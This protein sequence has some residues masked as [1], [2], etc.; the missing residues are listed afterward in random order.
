MIGKR[1]AKCQIQGVFIGIFLLGI[2][3]I[4]ILRISVILTGIFGCFDLLQI[5]GVRNDCHVDLHIVAVL[6]VALVIYI[7][8]LLDV[9]SFIGLL[10]RGCFDDHLLSEQYLNNALICVLPNGQRAVAL[11]RECADLVSTARNVGVV[12]LD[13]GKLLQSLDE[14]LAVSDGNGKVVS[15]VHDVTSCILPPL[16]LV[17]WA[18]VLL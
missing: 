7:G 10:R 13:A 16:R 1:N 2:V 3:P 8:I 17:R 5:V 18:A 11:N 14:D 9:I 15:V 6:G 4:G 12:C